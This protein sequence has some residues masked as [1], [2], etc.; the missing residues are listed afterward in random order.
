MLP[1]SC[2]FSSSAGEPS[3]FFHF[4]IPLGNAFFWRPHK[5]ISDQLVCRWKFYEKPHDTFGRPDTYDLTRRFFVCT[6]PLDN[7][8]SAKNSPLKP[9][10]CIFILPYPTSKKIAIFN[11]FEIFRESSRNIRS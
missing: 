8:G 5:S 6:V 10:P 9:P 3:S 11:M 2:N 7:L 4:F 1:F